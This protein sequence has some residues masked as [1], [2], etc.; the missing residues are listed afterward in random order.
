MERSGIL[1]LIGVL[2]VLLAGGVVSAQSLSDDAPR[3]NWDTSA[4]TG[5]IILDGESYYSVFQ[6]EEDIEGWRNVDGDDVTGEILTRT[7]GG[8]VLE[9]GRSVDEE[10]EPGR[11]ES[12]DGELTARVLSPRVSRFN[13][14]NGNGVRLSAD[15]GVG[16]DS[17]LLVE[18]DWN[19][20]EAEDI[21]ITVRDSEG[22]EITREVLTTNPTSAQEDILPSGFS[23]SFLNRAVQGSGS[24]G[25]SS[26]YW[27]L[28]PDELPA[29][30]NVVRVAGVENL[31]FGRATDSMTI[32][33][34]S[35]DTP[36]LSLDTT[37]VSQGEGI[38]FT[39]TGGESGDYHAVAVPMRDVRS[40]SNPNDVFRYV[41]DTLEVGSTG[42]YAYAVVRVSSRG[43][44]IGRLDSTHLERGSVSVRLYRA[45]SSVGNARDRI[46]EREA[47]TR[48][49]DIERSELRHSLGGT[50]VTGQSIDVS[51]TASPGVDRVAIYVRHRGDWEILPL[52]GRDTT[53]VRSDGTWVARN[54]VLSEEEY[55]GRNF[56]FPGTYS[57]AV[58]DAGDLS[59]PPPR[60]ISSSEFG[61]LTSSRTTTRVNEPSFVADIRSYNREV[62]QGDR[63]LF[64]GIST[65]SRDIVV[66]FVGDR[67]VRAE[68][69]RTTSGN[70]IDTNIDIGEMRQG[71][72][73]AF[74]VSP[75]R[76]G[77]FGD[78]SATDAD[79][80]TV[81]I[82]TPTR[83]RD[84]VR[85]FDRDG[86]TRAQRVS[87]I[88][89]ATVERAGSDDL[90]RTTQFRVREPRTT[91]TDIVPGEQPQ[92]AGIVPI[93]RGESVLVR[94]TT[95][96]NPDDT[97]ITVEITD[98]PDVGEFDLVT[99]RDWSGGTWSATFGTSGVSTGTY[100]VEVDD[101][102][103][104]DRRSFTVVEDR[105]AELEDVETLR[106]RLEEITTELDALRQDNNRTRERVEELRQERDRLR[107]QV[108]RTETPEDGGDDD[109][110]DGENGDDGGEGMPGF[111]AV[112]A[113]VAIVAFVYFVRR[114]M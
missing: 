29:G 105:E 112:A 57:I 75:G 49:I 46:G 11:Y 14:Y 48:S 41:G 113:L 72:V 8:D 93:E 51:G 114:S 47:D 30:R 81:S 95:N 83:F 17:P 36:S 56:R 99:I 60:T 86:R 42:D 98:G 103:S 15:S 80:N 23:G 108:N 74:A 44:A 20:V 27:L 88:R 85:S 78:G 69:V 26:A 10:Q 89:D 73:T 18:A 50:Y 9:L 110:T 64:R 70:V 67:D 3:G 39:V 62:A 66:G 92:L 45:G 38:Q 25:Y 97:D 82:T 94:G 34:G 90:I 107:E 91:V 28:D 65:G 87:R 32:S 54:V 59:S 100:T 1:V 5:E 109:D 21:E 61:R 104:T 19:F 68:V 4:S 22:V 55:G 12:D 52:N 7:T 76:D 96:R 79:G 35:R 84:Y 6:G 63:I 37:T 101:G 40:T 77:E 106:Q 102:D 71:E 24:T 58:V 43:T 13:L 16:R 31:D 53:T 111:T 33:V 2:A